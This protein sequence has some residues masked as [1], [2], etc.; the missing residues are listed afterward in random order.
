MNKFLKS[1]IL[2]ITV[3]AMLTSCGSKQ[4]I[5][6]TDTTKALFDL[7]FLADKTEAISKL[8]MSEEECSEMIDIFKQQQITMFQQIFTSSSLDISDKKIEGLYTALVEA[9]NKVNYIIEEF[10]NPDGKTK[11]ISFKTTYINFEE[12]TNTIL[13][14]FMTEAENITDETQLGEVFANSFIEV[15]KNYTPAEEAT[16]TAEVE[17]SIQ[18]LQVNGKETD[19]WLPSD[20]LNFINELGLAITGQ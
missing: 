15:L 14:Q 17:F 19:V 20:Q 6:A 5:S 10:E 2:F 8:G 16:I 3:I 12:L 9:F 11:T 7:I 1:M 13:Q 4:E 18:K